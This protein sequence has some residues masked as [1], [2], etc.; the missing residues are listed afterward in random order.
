VTY[1]SSAEQVSQVVTILNR[2]ADVQFAVKSGGHNPNVGWS[3]VDGGVLISMKNLSS[4]VYN[5]GEQ[6]AEIGPGARWASV[7]SALEPYNVAVVSGR[8]GK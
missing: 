4:T 5:A 7:L 3:S 6:T 1:P 2:Y 8:L